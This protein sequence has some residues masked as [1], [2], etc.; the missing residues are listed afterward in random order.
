MYQVDSVSTHPKELKKEEE[1]VEVNAVL[2][3]LTF[4]IM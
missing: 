1:R 3:N 2:F 4:R